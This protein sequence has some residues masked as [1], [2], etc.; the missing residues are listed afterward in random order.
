LLIDQSTVAANDGRGLIYNLPTST[1]SPNPSTIT[2]R[3]ITGVRD[4]N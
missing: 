4:R 2:G 1:P 3:E